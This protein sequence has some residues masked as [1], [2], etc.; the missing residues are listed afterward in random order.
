MSFQDIRRRQIQEVIDMDKSISRKVFDMEFRNVKE[1]EDVNKPP[2]IEDKNLFFQITKYKDSIIRSIDGSIEDLQSH[3]WNAISKQQRRGEEEDFEMEQS[4]SVLKNWNEM[5][6]YLT[7]FQKFYLLSENDRNKIYE[8]INEVLPSLDN[9]IN[10][11][12]SIAGEVSI[13]PAYIVL[14]Y[15]EI[16][17]LRQK[18]EDKNLSSIKKDKADS[19]MITGRYSEGYREREKLKE[20]LAFLNKKQL[21]AKFISFLKARQDALDNNNKDLYY[22]YDDLINVIKRDERIDK[23]EAETEEAKYRKF[24]QDADELAEE[25]GAL[26]VDELAQQYRDLIATKRTIEEEGNL[27][28]LEEINQRLVQLLQDER[29]ANFPQLYGEGRTNMLKA[30]YSKVKNMGFDDSRNDFYKK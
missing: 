6:N 13:N 27:E 21:K 20:D 7:N 17:L 25:A 22:K 2:K 9:Y 19:K 18:I 1:S 16:I 5:I 30:K 14:D 24:K 3:D 8:I 10:L 28:D 15:N 23:R 29:T 4:G 26:S 11:I 12:N